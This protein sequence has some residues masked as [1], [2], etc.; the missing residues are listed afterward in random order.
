MSRRQA[1]GAIAAFGL[2]LR[3]KTYGQHDHVRLCRQFFRVGVDDAA[4]R[5]DTQ[6]QSGRGP[7]CVTE[8]FQNDLVGTRCERGGGVIDHR[9]RVFPT[10]QNEF[11]V[12]E[13]PVPNVLSGSLQENVERPRV[14]RCVITRPTR[15]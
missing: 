15:R 8:V 5:H 4:A 7:A 14:L 9:D 10:I 12:D 2:S 6:A 11:V 3:I 1:K 13:Q